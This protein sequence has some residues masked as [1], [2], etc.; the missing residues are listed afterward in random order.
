MSAGLPHAPDSG[1]CWTTAVGFGAS[2][3]ILGIQLAV[4][5]AASANLDDPL[6]ALPIAFV[7]PALLG[8]ALRRLEWRGEAAILGGVLHAS[9]IA[10]IAC[11]PLSATLGAVAALA[12]AAAISLVALVS[13]SAVAAVAR[14]RCTLAPGRTR[15]V[16][17][18]IAT[19]MFASTIV[20]HASSS[21]RTRVLAHVTLRA[22]QLRASELWVRHSVPSLFGPSRYAAAG[23]E[24][25]LVPAMSACFPFDP[26]RSD[27]AE[28]LC[29][30][31]ATAHETCYLASSYAEPPVRTLAELS[32]CLRSLDIAYEVLASGTL[33]VNID[34]GRHRFVRTPPGALRDRVEIGWQW[35][36]ARG[37]PWTWLALSGAGWLLALILML[38]RPA[39]GRTMKDAAPRLARGM[40]VAVLTITPAFIAELASAVESARP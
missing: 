13:S 18:C 19:A 35:L 11:L 12:G 34:H 15:I 37:A 28:R 3:A 26:A 5:L 29:V 7:L 33:A 1:G 14:E 4:L 21:S 39:V 25:S 10:I 30:L 2:L 36:G 22:D 40:L 32:P 31:C 17:A 38:A 24:D 16:G 20:L 6:T 23:S 9:F 8:P 27:A